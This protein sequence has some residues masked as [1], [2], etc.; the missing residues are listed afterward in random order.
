M[1]RRAKKKAAQKQMAAELDALLSDTKNEQCPGSEYQV[2]LLAAIS[3]AQAIIEF[4]LNGII[5]WA[6]ENFLDTVEYRLEEIQGKHHRMFCEPEYAASDEYANFWARLNRGEFDTGEYKRFGNGGKEVWINASYNP[7]FDAEGKPIKVV[8]FAT[9]VSEQKLTAAENDGKI[10]AIHK[11]QAVIEFALDG[12]ILTANENFLNTVGY[13]LGEIQ[14]RHHR[15]FCEP[16]Y[17][18][19]SEYSN[20]WA[21]LNR[22]EFDAGEYKRIGNDGREIWINAS[23]NPIFDADGR[24]FKVVKFATDITQ[25]KLDDADRAGK[26]DAISK[27]Q[28]MIEFNLDGTIITANENFLS[29]VGYSL[30]EIQGQHHQIFCTPE[31][32]RSAEY[33]DFWARLNLGEFDA[34]EY[35]RVDKA[36]NTVWINASYNP[37]FDAEG[38]PF[39]VVKFAT[40][41]TQEKIAAIENRAK[42]EALDTVQARVEFTPD[43]HLLDGNE[44]FLKAFG[45]TMGEVRGKH[46]RMFCDASFGTTLEYRRFW[47]K[48]QRG[49]HDKGVY[50]RVDKE[51]RE[52]WLEASYNPILDEEGEVLKVVKFATV[53]TDNIELR[54]QISQNI[55]VV[56]SIAEQTNLLALNATIEAARAGEA[57]KGFAVVASEVKELAKATTQA[58]K[59]IESR[60]A[61]IENDDATSSRTSR[62]AE[63]IAV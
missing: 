59:D 14:G 41:I 36:G 22:G 17:A 62:S 15:M 29:T 19:S 37:I 44:N 63:P 49:E 53:V 25:Q 2:G 35:K 33:R 7:V 52:V 45:Y 18:A 23:Y 9:D 55:N 31:Y 10:A 61:A 40:N 32:A 1:F 24:P 13:S 58:T 11:A 8:K 48:L 50:Q 4:D 54:Q 21:R 12:T 57:G 5:Q 56:K 3:R 34:G 43:G 6:N 26:I 16:E 39:K 46:H 51:G 20:F 27:A 60:M 30:G 47:E 28:A 38:R 42:M